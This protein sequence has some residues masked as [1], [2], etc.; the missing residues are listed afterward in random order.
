MG[1]RDEVTE[2]KR[3]EPRRPARLRVV[4]DVDRELRAQATILRLLLSE[5]PAE[6]RTCALM[7][8]IG[9]PELAGRAVE[10][11]VGAGLVIRVDEYLLATTTAVRLARLRPSVRSS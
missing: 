9:E 7:A 10:A 4:H 3:S 8:R 5:R 11:L 1:L 2:T 6:L